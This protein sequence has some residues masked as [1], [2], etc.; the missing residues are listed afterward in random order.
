MGKQ[1]CHMPPKSGIN[2]N[3]RSKSCRS[4]FSPSSAACSTASC[5]IAYA[6]WDKA[7]Q[8]FGSLTSSREMCA[9]PLPFLKAR[10]LDEPSVSEPTRSYISCY[11]AT[12][13]EC[14]LRS[15]ASTSSTQVRTH[16]SKALWSK[17]FRLK[18]L[19][20]HTCAGTT[21]V[22]SFHSAA[23]FTCKPKMQIC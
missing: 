18:N 21:H 13:H 7:D 10:W 14:S 5:V 2:D 11:I 17:H 15:L 16:L 4:F 6:L 9:T 12:Y 3:A 19:Q 22:A 8:R 1:L 20:Y 23:L